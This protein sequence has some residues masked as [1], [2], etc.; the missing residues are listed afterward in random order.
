M[1]NAYGFQPYPQRPSPDPR[2]VG[3]Q[4]AAA[5]GMG[6]GGMP[7]GMPADGMSDAF[8]PMGAGGPPADPDGVDEGNPAALAVAQDEAQLRGQDQGRAQVDDGPEPAS[9]RQMRKLGLSD[10]EIQLLLQSGGVR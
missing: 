4:L 6:G 8:P 5:S 2:Q 9:I 10:M 3:A 7:G 1:P